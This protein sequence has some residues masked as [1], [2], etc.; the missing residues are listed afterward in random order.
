MEFKDL[1]V[2]P[3]SLT[4]LSMCNSIYFDKELCF[5]YYRLAAKELSKKQNES[6]T[7]IMNT[8]NEKGVE[9]REKSNTS[10]CFNMVHK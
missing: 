3:K 6:T 9:P 1:R 4:V 7:N 5:F 8:S 10:I 2:W